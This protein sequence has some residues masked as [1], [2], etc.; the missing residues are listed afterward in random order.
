MRL[1]PFETI[2]QYGR[3]TSRPVHNPERGSFVQHCE[4]RTYRVGRA[5]QADYSCLGASSRRIALGFTPVKSDVLRFAVAEVELM[6]SIVA[7]IFGPAAF[8]AR[9]RHVQ[10]R[11]QKGT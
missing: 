4:K 8:A 10:R 9:C 7:L 2:V 3:T 1:R 11:Y 6:T 5:H